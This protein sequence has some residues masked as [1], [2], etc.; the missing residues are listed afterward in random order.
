MIL[1]DT[2]VWIDHFRSTDPELQR[3]LNNDEIVMHPFVV[4]EL[5]LGPL[6]NRRRI[7]AYLDQLPRCGP[8]SSN[9]V[10]QMVEASFFAQSLHLGLSM[11]T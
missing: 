1:A 6:P 9:E 3:R 7:L 2:S 10:R 11:P 4:A 8:C 5:A